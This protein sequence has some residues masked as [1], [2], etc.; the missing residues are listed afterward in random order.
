MTHA[1]YTS[2]R[3][4]Q[5]RWQKEQQLIRRKYQIPYNTTST[6]KPCYSQPLAIS[7]QDEYL[8]EQEKTIKTH[9]DVK[10]K[11]NRT[12]NNPCVQKDS[13]STSI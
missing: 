3:Q 10:R 11:V 7:S 13:S 8:F 6:F 4:I 9:D 1:D 2:V 12:D 5:Y